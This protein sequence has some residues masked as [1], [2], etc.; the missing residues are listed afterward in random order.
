MGQVAQKRGD[1]MGRF[2]NALYMGDVEERI[3]ILAE[4]G[5][6]KFTSILSL[7]HILIVHLAYLTAITHNIPEL[8]EPLHDSLKDNLPAF[9]VRL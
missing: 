7:T 6:R 1:V 4:T 8:A 9:N 3:R 5:L 2:H